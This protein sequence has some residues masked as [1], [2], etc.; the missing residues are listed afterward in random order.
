MKLTEKQVREYVDSH[1]TRCPECGSDELRPNGTP[2][3]GEEGV[4]VQ[5]VECANCKM[6]FRDEYTLTGVSL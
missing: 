2:M 3:Y 6:K 4:L 1:G 5:W